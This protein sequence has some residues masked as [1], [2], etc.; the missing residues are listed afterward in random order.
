MVDGKGDGVG[1]MGDVKEC[2]WKP[3]V[4]E[5]EPFV[6]LTSVCHLTSHGNK[7]AVPFTSH[8]LSA[9]RD[10]SPAIH[11]RSRV[12]VSRPATSSSLLPTR[13]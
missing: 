5:V 1:V 9:N 13:R 4:S 11:S 6:C 12:Y 8:R 7:T 2:R 10:F 3:G